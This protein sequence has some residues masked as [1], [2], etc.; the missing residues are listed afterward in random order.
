MDL[1][2]RSSDLFA[3]FFHSMHWIHM[4]LLRSILFLDPHVHHLKNLGANPSHPGIR[5][6]FGKKDIRTIW[7]DQFVP[8]EIE[9]CNLS[10][11]NFEGTLILAPLR[12]ASSDSEIKKEGVDD[13]EIEKIMDLIRHDGHLWLLFLKNV[14]KLEVIDL[15]SGQ[16][17]CL[18]ERRMQLPHVSINSKISPE[19]SM[20]KCKTYFLCNDLEVSVALPLSPDAKCEAGRVF[21]RLPMDMKSGFAAHISALFWTSADR[22]SIVLDLQKDL[23]G[24]AQQ[25]HEHL[26]K[27]AKCLVVSISK[28]GAA[29]EQKQTLLE[30]FPHSERPSP[31]AEVL[32]GLFYIE[33]VRQLS[34]PHN[35][36]FTVS[37]EAVATQGSIL[38]ARD[39]TW[40]Q[41]LRA[42][43][44]PLVRVTED[45]FQGLTRHGNIFEELSAASVRQWLRTSSTCLDHLSDEQLLQ[46]CLQDKPASADLTGC[47]L[48]LRR[49]GKVTRFLATI[50][51]QSPLFLYCANRE[52]RQLAQHFDASRVLKFVPNEIL[53][54]HPQ[55]M[56][57]DMV[58]VS[59]LGRVVPPTEQFIQDFWSWYNLF[60]AKDPAAKLPEHPSVKHPL[61]CLQVLVAMEQGQRK[62]FQ[63]SERRRALTCSDIP[64]E[65]STALQVCNILLVSPRNHA[66]ASVCPPVNPD[67]I[68][69]ALVFLISNV[70]TTLSPLSASPVASRALVMQL[71]LSELPESIEAAR[72][73]PSFHVW[74]SQE[75]VLPNFKE[76]F[77]RGAS[78]A[79]RDALDG[80]QLKILDENEPRLVELLQ[81]MGVREM[82][83]QAIAEEALRQSKSLPDSLPLIAQLLKEGLG[84]T[85]RGRQVFPCLSKNLLASHECLLWDK[86]VEFEVIPRRMCSTA[87]AQLQ[88]L[89]GKLLEIGC[90]S[91]MDLLDI[92]DLAQRVQDRQDIS[93][94][95]KLIKRLERHPQMNDICAS[96]ELRS[97]KWLPSSL[98]S[99]NQELMAPDQDVW[100]YTTK[101][102]VG[103]VRPL[104]DMQVS[105]NLLTALKVPGKDSVNDG[106]LHEQ[107]AACMKIDINDINAEILTPIYA[108]L[109]SVPPLDNWVWTKCGFQP[110]AHVSQDV[111]VEGLAPCLHRLRDDWHGLKVFETCNRKL[112][113]ELLFKCLDM[114]ESMTDASTRHKVR[115]HAINLLT[116]YKT[117]EGSEPNLADVAQRIGSELRIVTVNGNLLPVQSVFFHDMKWQ[118]EGCPSGMEEVHG[119]VSQSS[120]L[121]FGV[122]NLSE[123]LAGECNC[124]DGDWL[125]ITGQHE[126]L[127]RRLKN[128]LKDYPWQALV[129]EMLQNAEDAGASTFK[130]LIDRRPRGVESLLTEQM[131]DLQGPCLWFFNDAVFED[132]DFQAL[133]SLGQ[134]SKSAEKGKIGRHGLGFNAIFNITDVPSIISGECLGTKQKA[135]LIMV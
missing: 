17:F 45:V 87:G 19:A 102:L 95:Q 106:V 54:V 33:A 71:A 59:N 38:L 128:I 67:S 104:V 121:R 25:N 89:Q 5:L 57:V 75:V 99:G 82:S 85:I 93:L 76:M 91:E 10:H 65:L 23:E 1:L 79:L 29:N 94:A 96:T 80:V 61:D 120:C 108:L 105:E 68:A 40:P 39:D 47:P 126:P 50:D 31:V 9:G 130:V 70:K 90:R 86:E 135:T 8:Y 4:D 115:V 60:A 127:T 69:R 103:L 12:K 122:R 72:H 32:H 42:L 2:T 53:Q 15:Q 77:P 134:G 73:L 51:E 41:A 117:S 35:I 100:Q 92:L 81:K 18:H 56:K 112:T 83:L 55:V 13:E 22:R 48:I 63:L 116:Q 16:T 36:L 113:P 34:S 24:W 46:F 43:H 119:D 62:I 129:K 101:P 30:F 44:A 28:Q 37:G 20:E 74:G 64:S 110:M 88:G 14:T 58:S 111:E 7:P 49:D 131:A 11:G 125:E 133:V 123:I 98:P 132:K 84:E 21:S 109:Q 118:S 124:G 3:S 66:D 26:K 97:L 114:T 52:E 27:I 78:K 6:N 107:L